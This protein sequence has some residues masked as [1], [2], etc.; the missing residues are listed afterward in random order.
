MLLRQVFPIPID[1][2]GCADGRLIRERCAFCWALMPPLRLSK[3]PVCERELELLMFF[4]TPHRYERSLCGFFGKCPPRD[5]RKER[6]SHTTAQCTGT[7]H[8]LWYVD[9][10]ILRR[11]GKKEI[12]STGDIWLVHLTPLFAESR[13]PPKLLPKFFQK[14][15]PRGIWHVS[16][17]PQGIDL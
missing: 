3:A 12:Q 4:Q 16:A 1:D 8:S 2:L 7:R 17:A 5:H 6:L 13:Y 10:S 9:L 11:L 15:S 14:E